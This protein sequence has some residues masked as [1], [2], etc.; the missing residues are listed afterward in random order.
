MTVSRKIG[1]LT[2]GGDAPG[3]NAVIRGVTK[4]VMSAGIEVYGLKAGWR[5]AIT[6]EGRWLTEADIDGIQTQGGTILRSSRTNVMKVEDG[7]EKVR[8]TMEKLGLEGIV[9][10]GGDDTL[11]V[12]NKLT[13]MGMPMVGVPKTIDNDLSCTDYTFGFDTASNI[14]MEAI[15][16]LHTTAQAHMRTM[17]VEIMGRH[18]GWIAI[19]AGIAGNAHI[20]L[21]PEYP[22]TV[23]EVCNI[24][25]KRLEEGKE[26]T[27]IAVAEGFSLEGMDDS[28]VPRD[29]FGNVDM[30]QKAI[31]ETLA[32]IIEERTGQ[33]TRYVVL[34]H[35]QR[36][37][38]PS[39]FDRVLGTRLGVKAGELVIDKKYGN[40]VGLSGTEVVVADLDMAVNVR[41]EVDKEFYDCAQL[42][43]G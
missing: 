9:A 41:K 1:I 37:G 38:A 33:E 22:K 20:V 2:G 25:K 26:Y 19:Q 5:G 12:A 39:A 43:F 3:L 24:V 11:G 14:T 10:I 16:R 36:G 27:M 35:L 6:G 30:T 32:R 13:K 8:A 40:M 31:G 18:T 15:D 34:G 42:F 21:I 17:V 28:D 29:A 23:D 4:K 7:P